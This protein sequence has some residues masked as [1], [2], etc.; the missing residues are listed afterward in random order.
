MSIT[1]EVES[2]KL[3][4]QSKGIKGCLDISELQ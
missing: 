2:I 1:E 4:D 3:R